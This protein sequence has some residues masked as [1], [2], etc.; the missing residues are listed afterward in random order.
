MRGKPGPA[1]LPLAAAISS[2]HS[3]KYL[4]SQ[5][6]M[7]VTYMKIMSFVLGSAAA[8]AAMSV[9]HAT[10]AV[11]ADPLQPGYTQHVTACDA[12]GIGF[13]SVNGTNTCMRVKG[14]LRFEERYTN[15]GHA[16]SHGR[17]TL[18]FETRSD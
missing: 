7:R 18:D 14:Q 15:T 3:C 5:D 2:P 6:S 1:F 13:I 12:Y 11:V 4:K 10:D 9:A 17:S 16:T 8:L